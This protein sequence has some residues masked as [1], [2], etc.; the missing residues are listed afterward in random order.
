VIHSTRTRLAVRALVDSGADHS[1]LPTR[2]ASHLGVDLAA[3]EHVPCTTAGG[4]GFVL[5]HP[6]PLEAEIEA[7]KVRFAMK[8]AFT[9]HGRTILLGRTSSAGAES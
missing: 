6:I 7:M 3:C 1:I 8:P 2:Y 9:A 4:T 5:V